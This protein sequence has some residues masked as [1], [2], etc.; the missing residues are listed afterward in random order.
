MDRPE[1]WQVPESSGEQEKME[2]TGC[3]II[4]GAPTT[5]AVKGWMMMMMKISSPPK[6]KRYNPCMCLYINFLLLECNTKCCD[7]SQLRG[8]HWL[9]QFCPALPQLRSLARLRLPRDSCKKTDCSNP[10]S[11]YLSCIVH[12]VSKFRKQIKNW[13]MI[14]DVLILC[15]FGGY[16][17]SNTWTSSNTSSGALWTRG[18]TCWA[19]FLR[20]LGLFAET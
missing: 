3:K 14:S 1:V 9:E 13:M 2:K 8:N 18:T 7:F 12:N 4:C 11:F 15:L 20:V 10:R 16:F 6:T 19:I 17:R 5:I